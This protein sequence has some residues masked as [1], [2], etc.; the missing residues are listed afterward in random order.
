[1]SEFLRNLSPKGRKIALSV[2]VAAVTIGV[3]GGGYFAVTKVK[4]IQEQKAAL[5]LEEEKKAEEAKKAA[6]EEARKELIKNSK[7]AYLTFDDGPHPYNTEKVLD[8]LA[9]NDIK[10]TFFMVGNMAQKNPEVVKKVKEAGHTIANHTT[11]HRYSYKSN[12]E[13]LADIQDTDEK[14]SAALGEEHKSLFV[15]VPGGSMGKKLEKSV[16]ADNGYID[17]N[18]NSLNG[19][20]EKGG[21][22]SKD[23]I[24]NR[25]KETVGDDQYEVV[26]MHDIKSVT[27]ENLQDIID[28]I[29]EEGYIF[30]PLTKD[31]PISFRN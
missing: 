31:S 16:L 23:Y 8:V 30:E 29:K 2:L 15:R 12:E 18:W 6:E 20:S 21:R 4:E 19:D 1:M 27:A 7:V 5:K 13:F 10:A 9:A 24:I 11:N 26:L 14:I 22:V 25:V 28:T 3:A 17:T